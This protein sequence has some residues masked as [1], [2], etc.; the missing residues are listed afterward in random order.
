[1]LSPEEW[2]EIKKTLE[3]SKEDEEFI[4]DKDVGLFL[5]QHHSKFYNFPRRQKTIYR[6]DF[7]DE[8]GTHLPKTVMPGTVRFSVNNT[9]AYLAH[10]RKWGGE[11]ELNFQKWP[12]YRQ[13]LDRFK[14]SFSEFESFEKKSR[15]G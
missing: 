11:C 8:A 3:L 4:I 15:R 9:V 10:H 14:A 12:Y 6:G 5:E 1:M 13:L 2:S 7:I